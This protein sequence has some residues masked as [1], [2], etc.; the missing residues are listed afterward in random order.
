M[1]LV[2][3]RW[4]RTAGNRT[5]AGGSHRNRWGLQEHTES[6]RIQS[7]RLQWQLVCPATHSA[8][9]GCAPQAKQ[10]SDE[11]AAAR[12]RGRVSNALESAL[13]RAEAGGGGMTLRSRK[14]TAT[15][16]VGEEGA[17]GGCT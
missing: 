1:R 3:V 11:A 6:I 8:M 9:H 4:Q 2:R 15:N 13:A 10:V 5:E 17:V 12:Q 16:P 7:S 14:R